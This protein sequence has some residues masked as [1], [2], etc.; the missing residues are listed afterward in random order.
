MSTGLEASTVTPGS[1]A[2]DVSLTT[3]VIDAWACA[4]DG[5]S[6]KSATTT[7]AAFTRMKL[8]LRPPLTGP[9][10]EAGGAKVPQKAVKSTR[11]PSLDRKTKR[12]QIPTTPRVQAPM[13]EVSFGPFLLDPSSTRLTRDGV[14]VKL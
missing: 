3:P 11:A 8:S 10:V 12:R 1:T 6:A 5:S 14:D 4:A 7:H 9:I 13:S 2:P